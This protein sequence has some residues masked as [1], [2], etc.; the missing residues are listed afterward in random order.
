VGKWHHGHLFFN[1]QYT[2]MAALICKNRWFSYLNFVIIR[3]ILL[4]EGRKFADKLSI[5]FFLWNHAFILTLSFPLR[6]KIFIWMTW[7]WLNDKS[8]MKNLRPVL[9]DT[10]KASYV[11]PF[12]RK[13]SCNSVVINASKG[14]LCFQ[15]VIRVLW[16]L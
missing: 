2:N 11:E 5:V 3:L 10:R 15:I 16:R 13:S 6:N 4:F 1:G 14:S 7:V 9:G 12:F 8:A